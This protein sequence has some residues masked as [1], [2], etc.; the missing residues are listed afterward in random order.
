MEPIKL[1]RYLDESQTLLPMISADELV[2]F[3]VF[4]AVGM[5]S[6]QLEFWFLVG[7]IATLAFRRF[8][9]TKPDGF[10]LH[11]LYWH[12]V[13]PLKGSAAINPFIRRILP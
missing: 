12:G 10:L 3:A 2:P 5:V 4:F 1:P 9:D 6:N 7:V 13:L 11:W 8:R